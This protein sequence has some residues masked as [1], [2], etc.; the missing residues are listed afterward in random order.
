M[1]ELSAPYRFVPLSRY[2][3]RPDWAGHVSHDHPFADGVCGE[4]DIKLTAHTRLCVGGQQQAPGDNTPGLVKFFRT[5]DNQLAIPG[6]SLKG[7]LRSVMEIACFGHFQQVEDQQ[8][9]VRDISKGNNFYSREM[10]KK[11]VNAGWL[12]FEDG[13]WKITPCSY[14]RVHQEELLRYFKI[15]E[16]DWKSKK[17]NTVI[18]RY[19]LIKGQ[20]FVT[21]DTRPYGK[22][23]KKEAFRMGYGNQ[24]GYVVVT[25]Q[26]GSYYDKDGAKKRE[27]IFLNESVKKKKVVNNSVMQG[28]LSIHESSEEWG[29]WKLKLFSKSK[30]FKGVPVFYQLDDNKEV[31]SLG[32]SNMYKLPYKNSLHDAIRNTQPG[33]VT[34]ENPDLAGLI[35]GWMNEENASQNLRG[36]VMPGNL[37]AEGL[38]AL[39]ED[40]PVVLSSPKPTFYPAYIHQPKRGRDYKTLMD[41]DA[42]LAGWKRYPVRQAAEVPELT[43]LVKKNKKVQ[44]YLETVPQDTAFKGKLRFHNLRLVELGALLWCLDFGQR[45]QYRHALGLGKSMGFG[46]VALDIQ[47]ASLTHNDP[48]QKAVASEALLQAARSAFETYMNNAWQKLADSVKCWE[49][50]PQVTN[51]LA[52]AEPSNARG[53]NLQAYS[54]PQHFVKAKQK[55]LRL[56]SYPAEIVSGDSQKS[57]EVSVESTPKSESH[58]NEVGV[59]KVKNEKNNKVKTTDGVSR[60]SLM[61]GKVKWFSKEKGFGFVIGSDNVERFFGV[62]DIQGAD[63]PNHGATVEFEPAQGNKGPKA[64][65][66]RIK[67]NSTHDDRS[68]SRVSCQHCGKRM[69]PRIITGPP[70]VHAKHGWTP[71]PKK[72]ICPFCASTHEKFPVSS[73]EIVSVVIFGL[74]ALF[75]L[76]MIFGGGR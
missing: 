73:G 12:D 11:P 67:Q 71:V 47:A 39:R 33:H 75:V 35:F 2:I 26:P 22:N 20:R 3:L 49:Q 53:Q 59:K 32:L 24:E 57:A 74:V 4:L 29:F 58:P 5:P 64:C 42:E 61:K 62:R 18:E 17:G 40:G 68:D 27:F 25:G 41:K 50:S 30:R 76:S 34:A 9:G 38:P 48:T 23:K 7:M 56:S 36:R 14:V 13:Q 45:T 31:A 10:I 37:H 21:Y 54:S 46:Q 52:M 1:T 66:V 60:K 63:L 16:Q 44:T 6:S 43:E 72:S 70:L 65:L 51:L 55:K 15:D 19:R 28:F 69:V 8:L